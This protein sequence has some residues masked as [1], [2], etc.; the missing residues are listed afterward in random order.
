MTCYHVIYCRRSSSSRDIAYRGWGCIRGIVME[1]FIIKLLE[2]IIALLKALPALS[3]Y[4][5]QNIKICFQLCTHVTITLEDLNSETL[6]SLVVSVFL[7]VLI[8][9]VVNYIGMDGPSIYHPTFYDD[10]MII[11]L[12]QDS[13]IRL[14][15]YI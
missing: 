9:L 11:V 3:K 1:A 4:M 13:W 12:F 6:L 10:V 5:Y 2:L 7:V 15:I 8:Y 14:N